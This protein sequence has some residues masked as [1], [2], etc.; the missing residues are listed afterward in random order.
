M[1]IE[2]EIHIAISLRHFELMNDRDLVKCFTHR[3]KP[4]PSASFIRQKITEYRKVGIECW[5]NCDNTD[6]RGICLGHD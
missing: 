4:K 5:P 2:R 1:E 6:A 3:G